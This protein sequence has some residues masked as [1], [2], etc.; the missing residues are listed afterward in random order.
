VDWVNTT[1]IDRSSIKQH[2]ASV[3]ING[4]LGD[5]RLGGGPI[6]FAV[7]GEYRKEKSASFPDPVNT[8]GLTFGN[9]LFPEVGSFDVVEGFAELRVPIL[10]GRPGVHDLT[11]NGAVRVSSYSTVGTT[12][13]YQAGLV[14]AP[15]KDVRFR[16]TYAQAVRAPN[17]GE[18]FGPQNQDFRSINDPCAPQ[19]INS[20]SSTR[21]ANC[22]QLLQNAGL[23]PAQIVAFTGATGSSTPGL[24]GGNPDLSEETAK[25]ITAGVILQPSFAPNLILSADYYDVKIED[26]V[27]SPTVTTIANLCVD[28]PTIEN[29]FCALLTRRPGTSLQNPGTISSFVRQPLNV[30][31]F[32]TKGIDFSA[33]YRIP[34]DK[35]GLFR[36]SMVGNWLDS[37]ITTSV[38]GA[39][40]VENAGTEGVPKWQV[41]F[42]LNWTYKSFNLN[43][44]FNYFSKTLRYSRATIAGNPDIVPAEYLKL[45]AKFEHDMQ[46]R[47]TT[48]DR[49]S[50]YVGVNN[51]FNQ[52]PDIGSQFYPVSAVGRFLYAGVRINTDKLF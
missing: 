25:T 16:G 32:S 6:G 14:Y 39:A 1:A 43:Y 9:A 46:L 21:A 42:D 3:S 28:T 38:P 34:T 33:Q 52:R 20:G 41:N 4:D 26:A 35:M 37:L 36:F 8:T 7:G 30:A 10:Q 2:V 11:A 18:L 31:Y 24:S 40:P 27:G 23:S 50:F 5:F 12:F 17:I 51:M 45:D 15:V 48:S 19:N 49:M 29:D 22:L 47:W 13:T 44:G